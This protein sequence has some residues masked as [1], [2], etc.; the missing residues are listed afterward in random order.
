VGAVLPHDDRG[1][2]QPVLLLHPGVCDRSMWAGHLGWL[3]EAG[4]RAIAVDLP[5]Y[6]EAQVQPGP[7]APWEDVLVTLRE[8]GVDRAVVVG[9]SFGA[10]VALR[11]AAVAPAAIGGL[12]LISPPPLSQDP[13]PGLAA[14]W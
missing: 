8:L 7:Q 4:Y 9:N 11:M 3:V 12:I 1:S 14:A 13:S 5:G 10:A 2:G 6:G